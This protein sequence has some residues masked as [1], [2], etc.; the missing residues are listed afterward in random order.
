[1]QNVNTHSSVSMVAGKAPT[2]RQSLV[3]SN[4]S[5]SGWYYTTWYDPVGFVMTEVK[6]TINYSFDGFYVDSFNGSDWR[7]W[8]VDGWSE[9]SHSIG[10]FYNSN[11][12]SATVWTEDHFRNSVFCAGNTTD[13]YYSDNYVAANG[14]GGIGGYKDTWD[15]GGCSTWL[16]PASTVGGGV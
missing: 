14:N 4:S 13:V 8:G 2:P 7:N 6:D 15:S 16:H 3:A 10:S 12:T 5:S 11:H 9:V 1:M